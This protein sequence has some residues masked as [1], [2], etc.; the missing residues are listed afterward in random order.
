MASNRVWEHGEQQ[1]LRMKWTTELTHQVIIHLDTCRRPCKFD[2][3]H[4]VR[5]DMREKVM[6]TFESSVW[7]SVWGHQH[8][9]NHTSTILHDTSSQVWIHL[10]IN[11]PWN[12]ISINT[13]R[14]ESEQ[15][16]N[17]ILILVQ[18]V[19]FIAV[20]GGQS[21]ILDDLAMKRITPK[22]TE[23]LTTLIDMMYRVHSESRTD[24]SVN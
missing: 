9:H 15:S 3:K 22:H 2:H 19:S 18:S 20:L 6:S 10:T 13:C 17:H 5:A 7:V 14:E 23:L 8:L 12:R 21:H 11:T 4:P 16:R 1:S 24:E